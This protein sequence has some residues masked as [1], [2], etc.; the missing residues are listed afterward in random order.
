MMELKTRCLFTS[1]ELKTLYRLTPDEL[2][3][4]AA[5]FET[6]QMAYYEDAKDEILQALDKDQ[7]EDFYK[8]N[9]RFTK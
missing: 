6:L 5:V 8:L 3:V 2:E 7:I 9:E 4:L 1:E